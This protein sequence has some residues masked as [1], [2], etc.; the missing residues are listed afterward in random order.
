MIMEFGRT[1]LQKIVKFESVNGRKRAQGAQGQGVMEFLGDPKNESVNQHLD[2]KGGDA[3]REIRRTHKK[4]ARKFR[5][6]ADI[7]FAE[8]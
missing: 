7:L 8:R 2:E 3:D 4:R 1:F 5:E 6:K